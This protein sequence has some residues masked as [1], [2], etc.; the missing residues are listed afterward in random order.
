M[1]HGVSRIVVHPGYVGGVHKDHD[2]A[3]LKLSKPAL[4]SKTVNTVCLPTQDGVVKNRNKCYVTGII[5]TC[6]CVFLLSI[7]DFKGHG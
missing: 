6:F 1:K 3:L 7:R 2:I 4:L 5:F